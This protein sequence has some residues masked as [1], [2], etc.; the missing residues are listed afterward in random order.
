MNIQYSFYI[1]SITPLLELFSCT[2]GS[3][4][5]PGSIWPLT[6]DHCVP[7]DVCLCLHEDRGRLFLPLPWF[8][9]SSVG[10]YPVTPA[11][12]CNYRCLG[13]C[14]GLNCQPEREK[15]N[16][17]SSDTGE[18]GV[19]LGGSDI[20]E[21]F[22]PHVS[23]K[24]YVQFLS[25]AY[26]FPSFCLFCLF[27][28]EFMICSNNMVTWET[29]C[30]QILLHPPRLVSGPGLGILL[31]I[32]DWIFHNGRDSWLTFPAIVGRV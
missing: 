7:G 25:K 26:L 11:H 30:K 8:I 20:F 5:P 12:N 22:L 13:K 14:A 1:Y 28:V 15:L 4:T 3:R 21:H 18:L 19:R 24:M 17:R 29:G 32:S 9:V 16:V 27:R 6:F 23:S 2:P 10:F 31:Y